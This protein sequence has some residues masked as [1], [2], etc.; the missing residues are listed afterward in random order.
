M[1]CKSPTPVSRDPGDQSVICSLNVYWEFPVMYTQQNKGKLKLLSQ[2]PSLNN[3][4]LSQKSGLPPWPLPFPLLTV[5][6]FK[7]LFNLP[8]SPLCLLPPTLPSPWVHSLH[9]SQSPLLNCNLVMSCPCVTPL[10]PSSDS[11]NSSAWL[12]SHHLQSA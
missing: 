3:W 1:A 10:W 2:V 11:L 9:F 5:L 6:L 4:L 8:T 7:Y 12:L